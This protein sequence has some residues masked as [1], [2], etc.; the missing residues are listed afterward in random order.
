MKGSRGC[1]EWEFLFVKCSVFVAA[2]VRRINV[3]IGSYGSNLF[4]SRNNLIH[5]LQ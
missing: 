1:A 4:F 5:Y 3:N 2:G